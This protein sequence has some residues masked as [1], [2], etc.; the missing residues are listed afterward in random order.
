MNSVQAVLTRSQLAKWPSEGRS[1][2]ELDPIP[3]CIGIA[4]TCEPHKTA[5]VVQWLIGQ[6]ATMA[7]ATR[8]RRR[9]THSLQG[10]PK[11]VQKLNV[12][13]LAYAVEDGSFDCLLSS[14]SRRRAS[15]A[16]SRCTCKSLMRTPLTEIVRGVS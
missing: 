7:L 3:G 2:E 14:M 16:T 10:V 12:E 4:S 5:D 9:F 11:L 8:F 6:L 15:C 13:W 1:N